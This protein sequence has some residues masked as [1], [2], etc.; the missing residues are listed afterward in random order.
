MRFRDEQAGFLKKKRLREFNG[1][2]VKKE[3]NFKNYNQLLPKSHAQS[4]RNTRG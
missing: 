3:E 1:R 4:L 2:G